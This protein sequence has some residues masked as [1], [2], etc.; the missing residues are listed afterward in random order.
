MCDFHMNASTVKSRYA[1]CVD[2]TA[3]PTTPS[4]KSQKHM[5][6]LYSE[7]RKYGF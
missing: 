4:S 7:V 5:C 3:H 2:V 1:Q 6:F